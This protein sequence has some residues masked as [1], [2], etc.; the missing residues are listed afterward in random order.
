MSKNGA[1]ITIE[2]SLVEGSQ[3]PD[4]SGKGGMVTIDL[5]REGFG[6]PRDQ[7]YY[8]AEVLREA[9]PSFVGAQM[10]ANHLSPELQ[11]KLKGLPRNIQDLM[12]RV[13]ETEIVTDGEG[14]T[15][16]RGT[17]SISQPW[18]WNMVEHDPDLLGVSINA[19]GRSVTGQ[20]DGRS[21]KIVEAISNVGSVD[22]VSKAGAGG[23]VFALM[24]AQAEEEAGDASAEETVETESSEDTATEAATS[25]H[26]HHHHYDSMGAG[27]HMHHHR[28]HHPDAAP[29]ETHTHI[30]L[31][32]PVADSEGTADQATEASSTTLH[33]HHDHVH[34]GSFGTGHH[35]HIHHHHHVVVPGESHAHE[36][37]SAVDV[38]GKT[39][40]EP[41]TEAAQAAASLA[42]HQGAAGTEEG[43]NTEAAGSHVHHHYHHH[44][45]MGRGRHLHHHHH[46]LVDGE[47]HEHVMDTGTATGVP[48]LRD[49][50]MLGGEH[51]HH[52]HHASMGAGHHIHHHSHDLVSGE[53]H[54]HSVEPMLEGE[55]AAVEAAGGETIDEAHWIAGAIKQKGSLHK[56][57]GIPEGE[58]IP[59]EMLRKAAEAPGKLGKRARLA[60]TLMKLPRHHG[61]R[62]AHASEA[63]VEDFDWKAG[64][65]ASEAEIDRR[66]MELAEAK[67]KEGVK[68]AVEIT[69]EEFDRKL[70]EALAE[71]DWNWERKIGQLEQRQLAATLIEKEEFSEAT[72]RALKEEFHDAYFEAKLDESGAVLKAGE[73]LCREGVKARIKAKREELREFTGTRISEAGETTESQR[74][75][76]RRLARSGEGLPSKA[77]LDAKI[78][79]A[80]AIPAGS[81]KP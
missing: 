64:E 22:W 43:P 44:A 81:G 77:P 51:N 59:V 76:G 74:P 58:K 23:K 18:L 5:I 72:E 4:S 70:K 19:R 35:V 80:L 49:A 73:D 46:K 31:T 34:K 25:T 63:E 9:A 3:E 66:A 14:R 39:G 45:T 50:G 26:H 33:H 12:G 40:A 28:H 54:Q 53:A 60:L 69:R 38:P 68:S 24:E 57:L 21:A 15:V 65:A 7:H 71:N 1:P 27:H 78:D 36:T 56:E 55:E 67:L 17:A 41:T 61:P 16:M 2:G 37:E 48:G 75:G 20:K 29:G 6:N 62:T 42:D 79:D 47:T 11:K 32:E 10:F 52:H 30:E 8:T 13:R